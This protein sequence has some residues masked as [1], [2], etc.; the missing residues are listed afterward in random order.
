MAAIKNYL[1]AKPIIIVAIVTALS[2]L[3]DSMLYIALP[4]YWEIAGLE[5][6][7][8]V[9]VLLSINRFI[10]L[11]FNPFAGWIYKHI[12]LKAGLIIAVCLGGFTTIG[13]GVFEGFAAWVILRALW[14]IAWSFFRI[15]GLSVV[16]VYAEN[17]KRGS[18][19][20][21]YNGLYRTG[22]LVGMLVGGLLVPIIGLSTVSIAFGLLS[23]LGLPLMLSSKINQIEETPGKI[24]KMA[25][26]KP[27][28]GR[29]AYKV[30]IIVSGFLIAMLYQG[31]VTS[32]MSSLIEH[33]YGESISIWNVVV[34]VTFLSGLIQALRWTWEPFLGK[35]VGHWSDRAPGRL[36][37]FIVSLIFA[38]GVFGLVSAKLPLWLWIAVTLLVMTGATILS[39]FLDT[40]ALDTA[41]TANVVSFLTV[42]T[43][44]QDVGAAL[45][46][47]ISYI[48]IQLE[49]GFTFLYWGGSF[50]LLI[51]AAIWT[52]LAKRLN[53]F[54]KKEIYES[55]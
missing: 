37:I 41:K 17:N 9:G 18:S 2:L 4:I 6:I 52:V 30:A 32:T 10:R 44:F 22:S 55:Y 15:G 47:A 16:A 42:Y 49:A 51:L 35:T 1:S 19:M 50:I 31:I 48:V 21:L 24:D 46:P 3:G 20:G 26:E 8:Q 13:Y 29:T 23:L 36:P 33:F 45:G 5:S 7:W 43:I 40:I 25:E 11:P 39:T 53:T 34:S 12:S 27:F 54:I 38:G 28:I 14:G